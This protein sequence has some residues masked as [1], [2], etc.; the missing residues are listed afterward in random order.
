[1]SDQAQEEMAF[2]EAIFEDLGIDPTNQQK[3]LLLKWAHELAE[4][5]AQQGMQRAA[6]VA[7]FMMDEE[8]LE[9]FINSL[10]NAVFIKGG[11]VS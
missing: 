7:S 8:E 5:G 11:M 4:S 10:N 3:Q 9:E 6:N 2:I 1:M